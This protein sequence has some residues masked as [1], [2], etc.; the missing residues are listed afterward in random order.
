M[1][2]NKLFPQDILEYINKHPA[3]DQYGGVID[4]AIFYRTEFHNLIKYILSRRNREAIKLFES[5]GYSQ[6]DLRNTEYF[7]L[8]GWHPE[9]L[10]PYCLDY[11]TMENATTFLK[12]VESFYTIYYNKPS[13]FIIN[14]PQ[15]ILQDEDELL[16]I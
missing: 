12:I 6:E 3:F 1:F 2:R 13:G 8:G 11:I 7:F 4:S 9:Y 14:E 16:T 5:L 15:I 10:N